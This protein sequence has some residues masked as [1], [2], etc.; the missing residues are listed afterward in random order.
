LSR[1][2]FPR[3]QMMPETGATDP[4]KLV[5]QSY[6]CIGPR[7]TRRALRSRTEERERYL[8]ALFDLVPEGSRVL[9]LGCG[10]GIPM[11]ARLAERFA[12]IGVDISRSQVG[13]ARGNVLS[14]DFICSDMAS[15]CLAPASFD[16]VFASY[17]LVHVPRHLHSR[18]IRSIHGWLRPGGILV[19][20][21]ATNAVE[22]GYSRDWLGAP[23]Y[24]S[25]FDTEENRRMVAAAGFRTLSARE[26]TAAEAEAGWGRV[27][28]LWVVAEAS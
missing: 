3:P 18:L 5:A 16:A 10:D 25:G 6:D 24:W 22:A 13:R 4:R 26:E 7:Y 17:S 23:M 27:T 8:Q 19:M 28:F 9:D 11:T 2:G 21:M 14:A 12:V 1:G 15:L 20:T